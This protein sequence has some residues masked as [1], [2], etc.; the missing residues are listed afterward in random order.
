MFSNKYLF[1]V[2]NKNGKIINKVY[3]DQY[4]YDK[5]DALDEADKLFE[6]A[7]SFGF[8]PVRLIFFLND[9]KVLSLKSRS[10]YLFDGEYYE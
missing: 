6:A 1:I 9:E 8:N 4:I 5:L 3:D 2:K 7:Y 10:S